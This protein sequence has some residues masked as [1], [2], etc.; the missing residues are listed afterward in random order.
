MRKFA[1]VLVAAALMSVLPGTAHAAFSEH[2]FDGD[3]V[4]NSVDNCVV[5]ANP[6]QEPGT[7]GTDGAACS[8]SN[9]RRTIE[10]LRYDYTA[11]ELD[12]IYRA[13]PAGPMPGRGIETW[14]RVRCEFSVECLGFDR[15]RQANDTFN[16]PFVPNFWQ[17]QVF[18]TDDTGG[19]MYNRVAHDSTRTFQAD[20][21]YGPSLSADGPAIIATYPVEHNPYPVSNIVLECR[22][23]QTKILFCYAWWYPIQPFVGPKGLLFYVFQDANPEDA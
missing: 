19:T 17:G 13:V 16:D 5:V 11:A 18:F 20:V 1:I 14:G 21:S 8:G 12:T 9:A 23:P 10:A 6:A 7:S 2:D 3:G 22:Q 15:H 4:P